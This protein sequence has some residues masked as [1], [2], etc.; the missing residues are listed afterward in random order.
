[1]KRSKAWTHQQLQLASKEAELKQELE[2]VSKDFEQEVKR[3]AIISV[4]SGIAVLGAYTLYKSLSGNAGNSTP[5]TKPANSAQ[6][7]TTS[8]P[9]LSFKKL[10]VEKIAFFGL[11]FIGTHLTKFVSNQLKK[12]KK[13]R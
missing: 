9:R 3:V 10:I 11:Q 4:V 8:K 12:E 6:T 7:T 13:K 2:E 5:L 1:M